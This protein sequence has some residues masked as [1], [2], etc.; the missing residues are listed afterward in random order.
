M[1]GINEIR[2]RKRE[3]QKSEIKVE[4]NFLVGVGEKRWEKYLIGF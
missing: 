2:K 1:R 3:R 4:T